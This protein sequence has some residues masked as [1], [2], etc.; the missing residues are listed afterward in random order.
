MYSIWLFSLANLAHVFLII[1][2]ARRTLRVEESLF[3][4]TPL[5]KHKWRL[6]TTKQDDYWY[7]PCIGQ[8][9]AL[10][11]LWRAFFPNICMFLNCGSG[12]LLAIIPI[13][14]KLYKYVYILINVLFRVNSCVWE[15]GG[16]YYT[17]ICPKPSSFFHLYLPLHYK[18]YSQHLFRPEP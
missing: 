2:P 3:H 6:C 10:L 8:R 7:Y 4:P 5:W 17:H 1:R 9:A 11:D 14:W 15:H 13:G 18:D 12:L 16:L